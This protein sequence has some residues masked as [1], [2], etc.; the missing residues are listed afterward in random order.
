MNQVILGLAII[1]DIVGLIPW[2]GVVL[3]PL[4]SFIL[5]MAYGSKK[6]NL[7]GKQIIAS[8]LGIVI[9]SIP[10]VNILPTNLANAL[11]TIYGF[12]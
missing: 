9:E 12:K 10:L 5:Y 3:N 1:F 8:L 2:A 7:F 6:K 11:V 4:F